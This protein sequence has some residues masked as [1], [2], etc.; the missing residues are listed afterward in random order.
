MTSPFSTDPLQTSEKIT[1]RR[2]PLLICAII[3]A[4]NCAYINKYIS[5]NKKLIRKIRFQGFKLAMIDFL[6]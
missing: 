6:T 4:D 5:L 2:S 3:L 1:E